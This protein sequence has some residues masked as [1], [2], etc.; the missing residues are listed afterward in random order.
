GHGSLP[1]RHVCQ[2]CG[3]TGLSEEYMKDVGTV[4]TYTVTHVASPEFEED[5]PYVT[6]IASF[7]GI[8]VT[9]QLRGIDPEDVETGLAVVPGVERRETT[10]ERIVVF[11]ER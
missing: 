9:G 7:D 4:E 6:A 2:E 5:T 3:A 1:P 11:R 10:D 8:A